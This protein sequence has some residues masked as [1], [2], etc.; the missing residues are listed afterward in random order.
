MLKERKKKYNV[1]SALSKYD[2]V[3]KVYNS[4]VYFT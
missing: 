1:F 3:F 4:F 2:F